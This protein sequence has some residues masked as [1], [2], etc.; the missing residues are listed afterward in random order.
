MIKRLISFGLLRA[1]HEAPEKESVSPEIGVTRARQQVFESIE[2]RLNARRTF[3]EKLADSFVRWFGNFRFAL[4][5][6][7]FF[8]VW[9][10]VNLGYIPG[11]TPFDPYPFVLLIT[12]VSLEAIF[13]ATFVLISQNREAR[14]SDLRE[15][16]DIQVNMIA[17]REI[18]K[19][20]HLLARLMKHLNVPYERDPELRRMMQPL[21][22]EEIKRELERQLKLPPEK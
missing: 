20:I 5:N 12:I 9:V 1:P 13:L 18:T 3:G 7:F 6:L 15:E 11:V 19:I 17:E 14:I 4:F 2:A 10:A 21:D 16:I 8:V 22:A